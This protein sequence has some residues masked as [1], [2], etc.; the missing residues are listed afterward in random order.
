MASQTANWW[1]DTTS[2]HSRCPICR[3]AMVG[4]QSPGPTF[5]AIFA[6]MVAAYTSELAFWMTTCR[7]GT[8][9]LVNSSAVFMGL[10][11]VGPSPWHMDSGAAIW[12]REAQVFPCLTG[13]D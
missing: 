3:F 10:R 2:F 11:L 8:M 9:R 5:M 13:S 4:D 7:N 1:P 12:Q 6:S